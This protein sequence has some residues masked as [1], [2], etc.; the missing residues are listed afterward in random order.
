MPHLGIHTDDDG[1]DFH[2]RTQFFAWAW[3]ERL[4]HKRLLIQIMSRARRPEFGELPVV[5][6]VGSQQI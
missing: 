5:V 1:F 4:L 2:E 3:A 6:R